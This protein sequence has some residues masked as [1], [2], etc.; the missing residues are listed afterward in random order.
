MDGSA[1]QSSSPGMVRVPPGFLTRKQVGAAA[2]SAADSVV[3][4]AGTVEQG[5]ESRS[6]VLLDEAG[7]PL[8]QLSGRPAAE[9]P[10]GLRVEVTGRFVTGLRTTAQQGRPFR[11]DELRVL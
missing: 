8:A 5:V 7:S 9:Y 4:L 6:I 3:T 10:L 1:E 11:V 2:D